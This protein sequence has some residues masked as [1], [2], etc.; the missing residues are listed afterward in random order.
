MKRSLTM[1][2]FTARWQIERDKKLLNAELLFWY[3]QSSATSSPFFCFRRCQPLFQRRSVMLRAAQHI[4]LFFLQPNLWI[5]IESMILGSEVKTS[6]SEKQIFRKQLKNLFDISALN[7]LL[8]I[9]RFPSGFDF[10]CFLFER[11][12]KTFMLLTLLFN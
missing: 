9:Q 8:Y 2:I 4:I 1:F 10:L 11:I 6:E 3:L 5:R 7:L 12:L